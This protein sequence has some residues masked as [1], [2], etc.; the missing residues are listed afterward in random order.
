MEVYDG[1]AARYDDEL[2]GEWGYTSP[3]KS[4]YLLSESMKL[5]DLLVLDAGC[6]T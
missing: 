1:W 6:G 3:Q 2:L 5:S 4:V